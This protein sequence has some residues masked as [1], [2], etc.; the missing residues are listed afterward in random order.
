[1][2]HRFVSLL[3]GASSKCCSG[4]AVIATRSGTEL[5]PST[6]GG[7]RTNYPA[8]PEPSQKPRFFQPMCSYRVLARSLRPLGPCCDDQGVADHLCPVEP[9]EIRT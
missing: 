3:I 1:M 7:Q 5:L 2:C 8:Y 6:P 9:E 4:K